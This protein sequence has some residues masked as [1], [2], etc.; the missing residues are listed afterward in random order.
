LARAGEHVI[1]RT[2]RLYA[3]GEILGRGIS[4]GYARKKEDGK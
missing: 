1:R 4:Y 2:F 3:T